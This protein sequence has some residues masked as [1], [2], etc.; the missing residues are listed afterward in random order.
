MTVALLVPGWSVSITLSL[1]ALLVGVLFRDR[2]V[3]RWFAFASAILVVLAADAWHPSLGWLL[4][5]IIMAKAVP[6]SWMTGT[7]ALIATAVLCI[8]LPAV[9]E[10]SEG[11]LLAG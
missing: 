1:L 11:A 9:R 10:W 4:L 5:L 7:G 2:L 8:F 6:A 3:P